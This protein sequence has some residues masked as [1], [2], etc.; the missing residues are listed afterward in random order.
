M[1]T[2][3]LCVPR[4]TFFIKGLRR[5]Y[6]LFKRT[7]VLGKKVGAFWCFVTYVQKCLKTSFFFTFQAYQRFEK[8]GWCAP[9]LWYHMHCKKQFENLIFNIQAIFCNHQKAYVYVS[10][11]SKLDKVCIRFKIFFST[12]QSLC[13]T[14]R[15]E[16]LGPHFLIS[17]TVNCLSSL[18]SLSMRTRDTETYR[19][20]WPTSTAAAAFFSALPWIFMMVE[21]KARRTGNCTCTHNFVGIFF[22]GSG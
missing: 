13:I 20:F 5:R 4:L 18:K 16:S 10:V 7:N 19:W 6:P 15:T 3:G 12:L 9:M 21:A 22:L 11:F 14:K 17:A 2:S 8:K 1:C